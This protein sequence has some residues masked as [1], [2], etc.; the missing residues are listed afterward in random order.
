MIPDVEPDEH[1][2]IEHLRILADLVEKGTLDP[3]LLQD[4]LPVEENH[5]R[6]DNA[7]V[8]YNILCN[9]I[10]SGWIDPYNSVTEVVRGVQN[11]PFRHSLRLEHENIPPVTNT[12]IRRFYNERPSLS[13]IDMITA[14]IKSSTSGR[15]KLKEIY[16][17]II[18]HYPYFKTSPLAWKVFHE[19]RLLFF[20][21]SKSS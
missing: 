16:K 18:D 9:M 20:Q 10:Q 8:T 15:M 14:A 7:T 1:T 6:I 2:L 13:Y 3:K 11:K 4:E 12:P 17:W 21:C 19:Y 5:T